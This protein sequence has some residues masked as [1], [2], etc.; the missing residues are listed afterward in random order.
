MKTKEATTTVYHGTA[1]DFQWNIAIEGLTPARPSGYV[2]V[3]TDPE[4]AKRYAWAWA[5]GRVYKAQEQGHSVPYS[6]VSAKGLLIRLE[7]PATC[8]EVDDYSLEGEPHQYRIRGKLPR[9]YLK[10]FEDIEFP[11]LLDKEGF[12]PLKAMCFLIGV[13]RGY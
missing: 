2:Y 4:I 13:M 6:D 9:R 12:A 10:G 1:K 11:D 8:L 3:T 7:V 5:G